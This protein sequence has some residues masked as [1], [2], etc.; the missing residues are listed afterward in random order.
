MRRLTPIVSCGAVLAFIA[1]AGSCATSMRP[2]GPQGEPLSAKLR[3]NTFYEQGEVAFIAVDVQAASFHEEG[4]AFP[5]LVGISNL[6]GGSLTVNRESF[7][8]E[9]AQGNEYAPISVNEYN[10]EYVRSGPD[11]T[12][13]ESFLEAVSG[14]YSNF[15][16]RWMRFFPVRGSGRTAIDTMEI[17]RRMWTAGYL[18]FPVPDGG[19]EDQSLRLLTE[20]EEQPQT[21]V[22]RFVVN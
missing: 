8:L 9:D 7:R 13:A 10:E 2:V 18:Y 11:E 21:F 22:V 20:F 12:L 3:P 16:Y 17:G 5:L 14:R 6:G 1:L 4:D 15:G 19:L